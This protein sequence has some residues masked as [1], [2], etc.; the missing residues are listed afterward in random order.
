MKVGDLVQIQKWCKNKYKVGFIIEAP[1]SLDCVKIILQ[2]T[3]EI[4]SAIKGNLILLSSAEG[5]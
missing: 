2:E 1:D 3:G 5:T 4:I